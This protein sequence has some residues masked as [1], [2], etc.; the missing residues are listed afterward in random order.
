M[1]TQI[2]H[3]RVTSL[4]KVAKGRVDRNEIDLNHGSALALLDKLAQLVPSAG[5]CK[6]PTELE[7]MQEVIDYILDLEMTLKTQPASF[8]SCPASFEVSPA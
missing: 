4:D 3:R 7:I 6:K 1:K 8:T 5:R 2:C